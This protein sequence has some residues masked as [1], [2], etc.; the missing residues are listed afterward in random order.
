MAVNMSQRN[1]CSCGAG[2]TEYR[3]DISHCDF[4]K[5]SGH[6]FHLETGEWWIYAWSKCLKKIEK[7]SEHVLY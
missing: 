5:L 3:Y 1:C 6:S 4:F 2:E 7:I